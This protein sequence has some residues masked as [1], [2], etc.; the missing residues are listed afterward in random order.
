VALLDVLE[1]ARV[2]LI[3]HDWGGFAGF[4]L[5]LHH[6]ERVE[7]YLALNCPVAWAPVRPRLALEAWRARYTLVLAAPGLTACA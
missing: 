1:L 4:L 3:G 6:P 2:K 5:A 7:R